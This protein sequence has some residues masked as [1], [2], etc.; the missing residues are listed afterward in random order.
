[1]RLP[2]VAP[3]RPWVGAL[4]LVDSASGV[5]VAAFTAPGTPA[6]EAGL[7]RDDLIV[8][9]GG[10]RV[11]SVSEWNQLLEARKPGETL[12]VVFRRRNASTTGTIRVGEDPRVHIVLVEQ[13]GQTLS[14]A[15][16]TFREVW[17][18]TAARAGAAGQVNR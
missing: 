2:R 10:T 8:T 5:R 9:L 17:L 3:G 6:Y 18:E 15:Q 1:M 16:R 7:D 13:T 11:G 14:A 12:P 4:Q